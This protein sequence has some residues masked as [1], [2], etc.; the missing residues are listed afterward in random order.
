MGIVR[1][2][3]TGIISKY[4]IKKFPSLIVIPVGDKKVKTYEDGVSYKKLFDFLNV[5]SETFFRVGE[6]VPKITD[7]SKPEKKAWKQEVNKILTLEIT[8]IDKRYS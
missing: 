1:S 4:K 7:A 3:E 6:E 8:R 5:F 2:S